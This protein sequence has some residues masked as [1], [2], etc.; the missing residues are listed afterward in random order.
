[1]PNFDHVYNLKCPSFVSLVGII[2]IWEYPILF[3]DISLLLVYNQRSLLSYDKLKLIPTLTGS[4]LL[5][6][7]VK[8][9]LSSLALTIWSTRNLRKNHIEST[10]DPHVCTCVPHVLFQIHMFTHMWWTIVT[11]ETHVRF[12]NHMWMSCVYVSHLWHTWALMSPHVRLMWAPISY[13][14][15]LTCGKNAWHWNN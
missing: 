13:S 4:H 9:Q 11:C 10:C 5:K 6:T 7:R 1:M 2:N 14:I 8:L 15:T 3:V 12:C